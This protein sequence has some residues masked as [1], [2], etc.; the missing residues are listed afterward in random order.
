MRPSS[1][2][3]VDR[4]ALVVAALGFLGSILLLSYVCNKVYPHI[5]LALQRNQ[6][7]DQVLQYMFFAIMCVNLGNLVPKRFSSLHAFALKQI[8]MITISIGAAFS[9]VA[10][11]RSGHFLMNL[12]L[13]VAYLVIFAVLFSIPVLVIL[14]PA[15][16]SDSLK[17]RWSV[18]A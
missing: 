5:P 3:I 14:L 16:V 7:I 17:T 4:V 9:L 13:S 11:Y 2:L 6:V 8:P 18:Q 10:I 12:G 15:K 1:T